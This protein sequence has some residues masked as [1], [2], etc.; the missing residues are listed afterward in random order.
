MTVLVNILIITAYSSRATLPIFPFFLRDQS[1]LFVNEFL[2]KEKISL[3][4]GK[5]I[6]LGRYKDVCVC[7][8]LLPA[9]LRASFSLWE[10]RLCRVISELAYS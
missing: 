2:R 3:T 5:R 1:G 8:V 4:R 9:P 6:E 7:P 10:G